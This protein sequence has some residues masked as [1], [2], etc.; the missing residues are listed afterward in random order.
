[1]TIEQAG[2][3]HNSPNWE[4]TTKWSGL[5]RVDD[6][7]GVVLLLTDDLYFYIVP[8]AAFESGEEKQAFLAHLREKVG[9]AAFAK[10]RPRLR[11]ART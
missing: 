1:M 8:D 10:R 4:S 5:I 6:S 2:L 3:R 11:G 9:A 7:H